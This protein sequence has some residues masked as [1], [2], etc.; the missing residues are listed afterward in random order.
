MTF[1]ALDITLVSFGPS[2]Y[3][4][5]GTKHWNFVHDGVLFSVTEEKC[6]T[7]YDAE[8][9]ATAWFVEYLG[10]PEWRR[11]WTGVAYIHHRNSDNYSRFELVSVDDETKTI[12]ARLIEK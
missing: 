9:A 7:Y 5:G 3:D 12:T 8:R 4:R 10:K 2:E 1:K 11:Q 6:P